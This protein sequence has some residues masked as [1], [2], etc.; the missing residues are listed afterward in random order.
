DAAKRLTEARAAADAVAALIQQ[1]KQAEV[2]AAAADATHAASVAALTER[3]RLRADIDE[4]IAAIAGLE[5]A[6]EE[7]LDEF[8]T[9]T[10][11]LQA[12]DT[13]AGDARAAVET[14]QARVD[15]ARR[16]V[17]QLSDREE[18]N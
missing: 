11:V 8:T 14:S 7:A 2:V 13:A 4:R 3:R 15:A 10:E 9:A 16:V 18:A 1:L 5:A 17:E 12:A 6:A